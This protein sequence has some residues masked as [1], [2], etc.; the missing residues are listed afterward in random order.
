[1]MANISKM[2]THVTWSTMFVIIAVSIVAITILTKSSVF[3][4]ISIVPLAFKLF[5]NKWDN[6]NVSK[7]NTKISISVRY[8]ATIP[9]A[10]SAEKATITSGKNS[11]FALLFNF[12]SSSFFIKLL[13][14]HIAKINSCQYFH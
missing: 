14:K 6:N 12:Y 4:V 9:A 7:N 11:L 13:Y 2:F 10:T 5:I 1:M 8:P 3:N